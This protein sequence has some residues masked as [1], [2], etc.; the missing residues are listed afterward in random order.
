MRKG[1]CR[2]H[3]PV[4]LNERNG[5]HVKVKTFNVAGKKKDEVDLRTQIEIV[6][7]RNDRWLNSHCR[8]I[9][10]IWKA[11]IDIQLVIDPGKVAEYMTK[12]ITKAETKQAAGVAKII[13][14]IFEKNLERNPENVVAAT[15]RQMMTK[16]SSSDGESSSSFTPLIFIQFAR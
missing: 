13:K 7:K 9:I 8:S 4:K 14:T 10:E 1:D 15:D 16:L 11:N 2:F 5:T 6:Q 12:Y 3:Y